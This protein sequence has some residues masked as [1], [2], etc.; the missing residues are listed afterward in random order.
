MLSRSLLKRVAQAFGAVPPGVV[1]D[2]ETLEL[3]AELSVGGRGGDLVAGADGVW[4]A[5]PGDRSLTHVGRDGQTLLHVELPAR[6]KQLALDAGRPLVLCDDDH[7]LRIDPVSGRIADDLLAPPGTTAVAAEQGSVWVLLT[8]EGQ[9]DGWQL[10]LAQLHP[11]TFAVTQ[12]VTLGRSRFFDRPRMYDGTVNVL[13]EATPGA[14]GYASFDAVSGAER[15]TPGEL[16]RVRGIGERGG[17]RWVHDDG[18]LCRL[19][20]VT[21]QELS[22]GR[23]G[24]PRAGS[25]LLAH[26]RVWALAW[27][28]STWNSSTEV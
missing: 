11:V 15:P 3:V 1:Y 23:L 18:H 2:A 4:F 7:L 26:G 17:V 25:F 16:L 21:G 12:T 19:D 6:P 5:T 9:A 27:S 10:T 22:S 20:A 8:D 24:V 13:H 14:M 28:P